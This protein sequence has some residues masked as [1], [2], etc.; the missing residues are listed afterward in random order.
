MSFE[1]IP[2]LALER[3]KLMVINIR[4]EII[5]Q[6]DNYAEV[7][8]T[9]RIINNYFDKFIDKEIEIAKAEGK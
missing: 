3:V 7:N 5:I 2:P 4:H 9:L 8:K 6:H 1:P